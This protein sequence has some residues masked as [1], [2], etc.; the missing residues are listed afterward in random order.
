MRRRLARLTAPGKVE[1]GENVDYTRDRSTF[2]AVTVSTMTG[3]SRARMPPTVKR[4]FWQRISET[5]PGDRASLE[6]QSVAL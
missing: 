2:V 6:T 3:Y 5:A 4:A 1:G